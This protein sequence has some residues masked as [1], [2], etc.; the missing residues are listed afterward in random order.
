MATLSEKVR[1][2]TNMPSA[3]QDPYGDAWDV[4]WLGL[5]GEIWER[6]K[7]PPTLSWPDDTAGRHADWRGMY[8]TKW[9]MN[10]LE[11]HRSIHWSQSPL[12]TYT[13]AGS[14]K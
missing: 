5:C 1:E 4:L 14:R 12:C 13:Y 3:N 7:A 9:L 2:F 10:L 11:G 6:D 8:E